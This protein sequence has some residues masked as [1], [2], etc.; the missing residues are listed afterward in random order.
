[1]KSDL[2]QAGIKR[3][4]SR[5]LVLLSDLPAEKVAHLPTLADELFE[6]LE[7]H[8]GGLPPAG[9]DSEFQVTGCIIGDEA[10]FRAAELMRA[11]QFTINHGRH[12]N[13]RFWMYDV[14]NDYYRRHLMLHE[15]THCFMSC[16]SGMNNLP[17]L[18][19][20]EGMAEYFATHLRG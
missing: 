6:C 12:F 11:G 13:Y 5:R 9:D 1:M 20:F 7:K 17:S 15:F 14:E 3:Y 8:F 19:Y 4:E 2:K 18:W 10:K 16:E